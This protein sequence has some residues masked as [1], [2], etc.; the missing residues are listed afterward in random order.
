[1]IKTTT[2]NLS[3]FLHHRSITTEEK[4]FRK[5]HSILITLTPLTD[6]KTT[7][8]RLTISQFFN[9]RILRA[10]ESHDSSYFHQVFPPFSPATRP[11]ESVFLATNV[12]REMANRHWRYFRER[13]RKPEFRFTA[14]S[15]IYIWRGQAALI[16]CVRYCRSMDH[17]RPETTMEPAS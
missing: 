13:L 7:V 9:K 1:M 11:E 14:M 16:I 17:S 2:H 4:H 5:I 10:Q 3:K 12:A 6:R 8:K 15:P